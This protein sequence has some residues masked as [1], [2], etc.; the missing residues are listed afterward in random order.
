[1]VPDRG[2]TLTRESSIATINEPFAA[3]VARPA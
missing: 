2:Y 1:M 3:A